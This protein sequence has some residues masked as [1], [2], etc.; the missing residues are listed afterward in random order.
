[1]DKQC[2]YF[3]RPWLEFTGRPLERELGEGWVEGVHPEDLSRCLEVYTKH[4]DARLSFEMEYR[5]RRH[6]GEYRWILDRGVPRLAPSGE[7]AGYIGACIDVTERKRAEEEL[8]ASYRRQQD[9]AS[10]LLTAQENE[11]R[12]IARELHDDLNQSLALLAVKLDLLGQQAPAGNAELAGSIEQLSTQVKQLSSTVHGLS[13][14][15]HPSKV[16][17]L[18]LVAA[19]RGL[20]TELTQSHGLVIDFVHH[21]V[22]AALPAETAV[23]LYRIVQEA[24]R[25]VV[26]HSGARHAAVE[27]KGGTEA[28]HLRISD[29]GVGFT[30]GAVV[31]TGG[32]GL[33]SMQERLRLVRGDIT[34]DSQ[35]GHG[36]RIEV[37]VPLRAASGQGRA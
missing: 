27:V 3:N 20:C 4:F 1:M 8:R 31:D 13:H 6:D 7:F 34:I 23:C 5:L 21:A 12:R 37:R 35:P 18:G 19:V 36:T 30:P 17:Q 32:L 2:T 10:R 14:Q 33:V 24:L 22:P 29:D 15:L 16:E 28:V 25:N 9:L 11:R 26:K